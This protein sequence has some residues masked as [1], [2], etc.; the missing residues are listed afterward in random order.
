MIDLYD[1]AA[2]DNRRPSPFCWRTKLALKHKGLEWREVP[3]GFTE[4]PK[5]AFADSTTVPV[6]CDRTHGDAAVKDSWEIAVYLDKTYPDRPLFKS[7]Q[8]RAFARFVNAW[9]DTAVHPALFPLVVADIWRWARPEDRD[10]FRESREKRLGMKLEDAQRAARE[11]RIP[12]YRG[13]LEP[14]RRLLGDQPFL[15]GKK[16][17]YP[18]YALMGTM[19]WVRVICALQLLDAVDPVLAWQERMLDQFDGFARKVA[20]ASEAPSG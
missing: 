4:K 8:A 19:M 13:T 3:V 9:T 17:G 12:A 5:I 7:G 18:D 11:T 16:P 1:L 10:Y 15:C 14:A 20:P 2:S 6:I